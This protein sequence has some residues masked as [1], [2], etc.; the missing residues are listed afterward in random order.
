MIERRAAPEEE[1]MKK[2]GY[3]EI[4]SPVADYQDV[5]K[6]VSRHAARTGLSGKRALLLPA[7]KSS[8]PPFIA[9]MMKRLLLGSNA[10]HVFTSNPEWPFFHP[11]RATV[12]AP[13]I[14]AVAQQ[15]DVMITG[16]AY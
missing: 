6:A 13:E 15:C 5:D 3:I 8:S 12:I 2:T 11:S 9:V 16:V 10:T 14:D 1:R 7:E 4:V